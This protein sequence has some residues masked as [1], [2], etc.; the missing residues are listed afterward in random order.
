MGTVRAGHMYWRVHAFGTNG[1]A[2]AQ[3]EDQLCLAAM[4]RSP[5]L[6][7][8]PHADSLFEAVE[9]FAGAITSGTA[10]PIVPEQMLDTIGAFEA[11]IGAA[12]TGCRVT[13]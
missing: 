6:R 4:G 1:W 10:F 3:G 5:E 2:E 7:K 8:L 12:K 11:V 9:T 13:L